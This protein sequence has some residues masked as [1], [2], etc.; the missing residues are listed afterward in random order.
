[1]SLFLALPVRVRTG[2]LPAVEESDRSTRISAVKQAVVAAALQAGR[3]AT[4]VSVLPVTK[5]FPAVILRDVAAAGF[6]EVGENRVAEVIAKSEVLNELALSCHMI[7]HLQRNKVVSAVQLFDRIDSVDSL[8]LARRLDTVVA[9]IDRVDLAVLVQVNA[10]G[11][12]SKGGF[13]VSEA[14]ETVAQISELSGL[15][16][17]GLMTMA[18]FDADERTLH[19][20]CRRM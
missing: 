13:P 2:R 1:M 16:V 20:M 19:K 7:G 15:R 3:D 4:S 14:V 18:P 11:E 8:R 10:S 5:G 12:A 6:Q 17:E 9:D